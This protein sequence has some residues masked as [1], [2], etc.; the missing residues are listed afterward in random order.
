MPTF[1]VLLKTMWRKKKYIVYLK[2][3][4]CLFFSAALSMWNKTSNC[5]QKYE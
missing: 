4:I 5:E 3:Q 1:R 2:S